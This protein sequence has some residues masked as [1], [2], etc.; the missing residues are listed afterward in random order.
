MNADLLRQRRNLIAISA[1]LLIFDFANVTVEKVSVLG[2]ELLVG[3]VK[4]LMF[5][6]WILWGY[7]L[8]RYYQYWNAEQDRHIRDSFNKCLDK[9]A[10]SYTKAAAIQDSVGQVFDNYKISRTGF[11][12]NYV[13]QK[14]SEGE[15]KDGLT[16]TLPMWRLATWSA[17]SVVFVCFQTPRA[18]DHILP[19]VMALSAPI[20][21]L[22][23]KW[24]LH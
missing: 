24:P 4:V 22:Y 11:S 18:T 15:M 23:T 3:N 10:R 17:K 8:L 9:Y 5:S 1:V 12:W 20:V 14:Y 6:A 7:F 21:A 13:L 16:M 19:F 2:T